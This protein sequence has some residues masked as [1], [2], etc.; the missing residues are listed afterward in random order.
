MGLFL[1]DIPLHDLARDFTLLAEQR[2][3]EANLKERLE[4]LNQQLKH[5]TKELVEER[6]RSDR[7]LHQMLPPAVADH[8]RHGADG[9]TAG[10]YVHCNVN[11]R[12]CVWRG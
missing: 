1:S 7:L 8:L 3:A 2:M 9:R 11:R 10:R 6:A 4:R 12:L 5:T